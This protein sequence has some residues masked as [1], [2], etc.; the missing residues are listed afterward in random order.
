MKIHT[1]GLLVNPMKPDVG[2]L[3]V[4]AMEACARVGILLIAGPDV[5]PGPWR[6]A[7]MEALLQEADALLVLGG[8]GTL[9]HA[10]ACMGESPRP[11]LGI[12]LG[13]LGFL[14]ECAPEEMGRAIECI[15]AGDFW[16]E[17][18]MLLSAHIE[19]RKE[20]YTALNDIVVSRGSFARMVQVEAY[21]EGVL[22]TRFVGD[23]CVIASPTGSTAYSLSAGGPIVFPHLSCFIITPIS[24]HT[25]SSRPIVVSADSKLRVV[26]RPKEGLDGGMLLTVDGAKRRMLRESTVL[27]ITKSDEALS[28]I[29]VGRE[30]F[31]ESLRVKLSKW[32]EEASQDASS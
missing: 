18:R 20:R 32:G 4:R 19:G 5:G 14:A 31:F 7:P 10:A 6:E 24:A 17:E 30:K 29:R 3:V 23:G 22:A 27:S 25:L 9:L 15:A 12:N 2:E 16:L 26:F 13:T 28:F 11:I 21:V 8:D 1:M